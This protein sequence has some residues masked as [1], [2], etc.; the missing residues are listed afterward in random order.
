[1]Q[2]WPFIQ[3]FGKLHILPN[4][5]LLESLYNSNDFWFPV[6][7]RVIE[8]PLEILF[9]QIND[10]LIKLIPLFRTRNSGTY[11]YKK[12][13]Y[14]F[15]IETE[16]FLFWFFNGKTHYTMSVKDA[17]VSFPINNKQKY[18]S[19]FFINKRRWLYHLSRSL[20]VSWL[21]FLYCHYI[22]I[23]SLYF[24]WF[25]N[26]DDLLNNKMFLRWRHNLVGINEVMNMNV[27]RITNSHCEFFKSFT[28]W[29]SPFVV[30]SIVIMFFI[31]LNW[32]LT[33]WWRALS[34]ICDITGSRKHEYIRM[35]NI[36]YTFID[37]ISTRYA[38]R[39]IH[40]Y[41]H[42]YMRFDKAEFYKSTIALDAI[43]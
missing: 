13:L 2:N 33:M 27:N 11:K 15:F 31:Q 28:R 24:P 34:H 41:S 10:L 12:V 1:M 20:Y 38:Y 16:M 42:I 25:H 8:S 43:F 32:D 9:I 30:C 6:A 29:F 23:F 36:Y 3:K 37:S 40:I 35:Y 39:N 21:S 14:L 5:L 26:S 4:S 7:V 22:S 18:L 19:R 17:R